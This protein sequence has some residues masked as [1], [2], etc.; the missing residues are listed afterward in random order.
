MCH[1]SNRVERVVLGIVTGWL[2]LGTVAGCQSSAS[3]TRATATPAPVSSAATTTQ[4]PTPAA[5][6]FT[7][8][9]NGLH[10]S[11]PSG[12]SRECV[13]FFPGNIAYEVGVI[14]T[15]TPSDVRR[16]LRPGDPHAATSGPWAYGPDGSFT[17][18][19]QAGAVGFSILH[20]QGDA[21]DLH[22]VSHINGYVGTVHMVFSAD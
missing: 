7:P 11:Q 2:F 10:M 3:A 20:F 13:R 14:D 15:A 22:S 9:L 6:A 12:G 8:R 21:F 1:A 4:A 17:S 19:T 5:A 18:N 16:W